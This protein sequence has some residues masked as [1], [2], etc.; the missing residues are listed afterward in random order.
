MATSRQLNVSEYEQFKSS[1]T[2]AYKLRNSA[3][4]VLGVRSGFRISELLSL[5][6]GDIIEPTGRLAEQVTV[7]K[8]YMKRK[9]ESRSVPMHPEVAKHLREYCAWLA[10]RGQNGASRPLFPGRTGEPLSRRDY[11]RILKTSALNL[12]LSM[13]GIST[14]TMRKTFAHRVHSVLNAQLRAG[15][16]IEPLKELKTA[17]GHAS[18]SSTERYLAED[19]QRVNNIISTMD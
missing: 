17:L 6:V 16:E 3:L 2:G 9:K 12:G 10:E 14:H 18:I 1:F 15:A 5:T 8:G 19:K 13:H 11:W 7:Q 4:F